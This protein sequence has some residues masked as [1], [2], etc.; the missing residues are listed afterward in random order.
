MGKTL[1]PS[2]ILPAHHKHEKNGLL[3]IDEI[4]NRFHFSNWTRVNVHDAIRSHMKIA[5]GDELN[6]STLIDLVS[7][8]NRNQTLHNSIAVAYADRMRHGGLP[9]EILKRLHTAE[10]VLQEKLPT[11]VVNR[12][13]GLSG[14]QCKQFV[15]Q[16]RI[17]RFIEQSNL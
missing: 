3:L 6:N 7:I 14:E 2:E 9:C 8:L 10:S 11:E 1:T 17:N 16:Y 13:K 4:A 12:L 15:R 5:K